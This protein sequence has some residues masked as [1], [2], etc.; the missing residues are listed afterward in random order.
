M[1]NNSCAIIYVLGGLE[2]R[3]MLKEL[4]LIDGIGV[5]TA[6]NTLGSFTKDV[7]YDLILTFA[8]SAARKRSSKN[9]A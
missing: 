3:S 7:R 2:W 8:T 9:V 4:S 6:H 5:R 1:K